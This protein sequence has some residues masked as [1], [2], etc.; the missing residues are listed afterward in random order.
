MSTSVVTFKARDLPIQAVTIFN[1]RA[2]IKRELKTN[3]PEG[4]HQLLIENISSSLVRDSIRVD[5]TGDAQIH[6]VKFKLEHASAEDIDSPA[7][8]KLVSEKKELEEEKARLA[9]KKNLFQCQLASLNAMSNKFDSS[10]NKFVFNESTEESIEKFFAFY[11]KK[12]I[13]LKKEMR[14]IDE[15]IKDFDG[16]ID[17][18]TRQIDQLHNKAQVSRNILVTV[19]IS[20]E[21]DFVFVLTYQVYSA[22]WSPIYDVRV[23]TAETAKEKTVLKMDYF[24][25]IRQSTG[26]EWAD[27]K[28]LLSTAQPCQGGNVPEL[29]TLNTSFLSKPEPVE[30]ARKCV[31]G[32]RGG[33]ISVG[34]G[35]GGGRCGY[36]ISVGMTA[37]QQVLSTEFE[38]AEKKTIPSDDSEHKMLITHVTFEPSLLHECVP[39]KSTNVFLTASVNNKTAEPITII[40]RE[41]VPKATDEKI[42][43]KLLQPLVEVPKKEEPARKLSISTP[44]NGCI[45]SAEHNLEWTMKIKEGDKKELTVKWQID[46]PGNETLEYNENF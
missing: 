21:S 16:K 27:A 9:D 35:R 36:G 28:I 30:V 32:G 15:P 20:A 33:G 25:V 37:S 46:Y 12:V 17:K 22:H 42:K 39:K 44:A 29:G 40:V 41:H 18:L 31:G 38:I 23:V 10:D 1:D 2:Q 4:R 34:M 45:L 24:A 6:E 5:G 8:E 11:D 7:I 14:A 19:N 3:L 43:V 26:E 13:G